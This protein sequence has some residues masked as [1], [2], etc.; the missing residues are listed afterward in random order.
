MTVS[1]LKEDLIEEA[2]KT[3]IVTVDTIKAAMAGV[4]IIDLAVLLPMNV[5]DM[6]HKGNGT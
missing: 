4:M 1:M 2:M 6:R 5:E 3:I